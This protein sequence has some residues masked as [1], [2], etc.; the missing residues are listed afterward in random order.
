MLLVARIGVR[1]RPV[2][3][4]TPQPARPAATGDGVLLEEAAQ[5]AGD[6]AAR[7][8]TIAGAGLGNEVEAHVVTS[9]P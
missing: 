2:A 9:T 3:V 5:L 7:I 6:V 1:V 8:G 4:T